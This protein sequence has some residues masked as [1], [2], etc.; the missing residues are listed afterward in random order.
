MTAY[1]EYL[2]VAAEWEAE[3]ERNE[4]KFGERIHCRRGCTDCCHHPFLTTEL[5][6]AY[7][8][9]GVKEL[10]PEVQERLKQRARQYI[11]DR[12]ELLAERDVPDA[13]GSLPPPGMRLACPA[14]EDGACRIYAH[15]PLICRKYGIPLYNPQKPD[16]LFACE[17]NFKPGE[18]IEVT[19][20]VQIQTQYSR[21]LGQRAGGLQSLGRPSRPQPADRGP[22]YPGRLRDLPAQ[23]RS[24]L[25][26]TSE[27]PIHHRAFTCARQA[28]R[29]FL[30]HRSGFG[31]NTIRP[32]KVEP[33]T[34]NHL[35]YQMVCAARH[36]DS[37]PEVNLPLRCEVQVDGGKNLL[38]LIL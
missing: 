27:N 32:S 22:R 33:I 14:L 28:E 24:E 25:E 10:P 2:K 17:L 11:R 30:W 5:E 18:E 29:R 4:R 26:S 3:F 13:W 19:E 35:Q 8:S 36:A 20:L 37:D 12:E 16:R 9:R 38:L 31:R 21:P 7:V 6:A 34:Q 1:D 15:R 23:V